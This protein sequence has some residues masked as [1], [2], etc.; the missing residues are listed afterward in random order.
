MK[1][2]CSKA[3]DYTHEKNRMCVTYPSCSDGC[4]LELL[5]CRGDI[6]QKKIDAVQKWSDDHPKKTR[7]EAFF[8]K[9]PKS[10]IKSTP[11]ECF[12]TLIGNLNSCENIDCYDC[13][14][15]PYNGEFE[16]AREEE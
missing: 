11:R 2:D 7:A 13:W 6:T 9:F 14:K 15:E 3:L 8:E 4:P 16:K 12:Y 5:D 1:Y 10:C